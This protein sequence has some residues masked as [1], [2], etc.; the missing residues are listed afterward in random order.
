MR[1]FLVTI[2][3]V[4]MSRISLMITA[5]VLLLVTWISQSHAYTYIKADAGTGDTC[6]DDNGVTRKLNEEWT[7]NG[8]RCERA[9]C[10]KMDSKLFHNIAG[11]GK[12]L[13][14]DDCKTVRNT[15]STVAYPD[16]CPKM[17]C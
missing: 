1:V 4:K 15:S 2:S 6:T 16:C 5:V 3:S 12:M 10:V 14:P 13:I 8:E 11:C 17:E 9:I 7:Y